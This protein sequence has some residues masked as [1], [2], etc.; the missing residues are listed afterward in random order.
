MNQNGS[1]QQKGVMLDA[2]MD[3]EILAA[4]ALRRCNRRIDGSGEALVRKDEEGTP[5]YD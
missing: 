1:K 5:M 4:V 3:C 2:G